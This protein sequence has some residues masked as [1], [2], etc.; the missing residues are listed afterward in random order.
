M[1]D[2][3]QELDPNDPKVFT[4]PNKVRLLS[5]PQQMIATINMAQTGQI[6]NG[7]P[8]LTLEAILSAAGYNMTMDGQLSGEEQLFLKNFKDKLEDKEFKQTAE[9]LLK[10]IFDNPAQKIVSIIETA[11]AP[12]LG[13]SFGN[14]ARAQAIKQLAAKLISD[15][16]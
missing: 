5:L 7:D 15:P 10:V 14:A 2:I 9:E 13:N 11:K 4:D 6:V 12:E 16:D 3:V 8:I 1:T